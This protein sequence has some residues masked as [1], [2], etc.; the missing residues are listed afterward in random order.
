MLKSLPIAHTGKSRSAVWV[1]SRSEAQSNDA[2][3]KCAMMRLQAKSINP[4]ER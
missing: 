2:D 3:T 1:E 4:K